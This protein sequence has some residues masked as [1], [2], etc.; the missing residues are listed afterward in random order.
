MIGMGSAFGAGA[1]ALPL[2][3]ASKTSPAAG[4]E[5]VLS[6]DE[7]RQFVVA[8]SKALQTF[9]GSKIAFFY[10]A[11]CVTVRGDR[12]IHSFKTR[13]E[14]EEFFQGVAAKY[15][16]DGEANA[17]FHD[18]VVVPIGARSAIPK[19]RIGTCR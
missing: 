17:R 10:H 7:A 15:K 18:L 16:R 4:N 3:S 13:V 19:R 2:M 11:P 9:D 6:A 12:S 5:E 8:Y 14:I 1:I